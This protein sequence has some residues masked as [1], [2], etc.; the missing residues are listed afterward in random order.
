M[1]LD[2]L[3]LVWNNG[4]GKKEEDEVVSKKKKRER[5]KWLIE[6]ECG[7]YIY[8]LIKKENENGKK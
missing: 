8:F 3:G 2:L 6:L 4:D 1:C 7:P 5:K